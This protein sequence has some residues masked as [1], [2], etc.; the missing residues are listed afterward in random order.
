MWTKIKEFFKYIFKTNPIT[1]FLGI[2]SIAVLI[3]NGV[4]GNV[5]AETLLGWLNDPTT[6]TATFY[7]VIGSLG[8]SGAVFGGAESNATAD[9]RKATTATLKLE[10]QIEKIKTK[11]DAEFA[12]LAEEQLALENKVK[13][14]AEAKAKEERKTALMVQLKAE[15]ERN[16]VNESKPV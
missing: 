2:G 15:A 5:I 16:K 6:I 7:T 10:K 1:I 11:E 3:I 9:S 13:D 14:E 8:I 4:T 12:K